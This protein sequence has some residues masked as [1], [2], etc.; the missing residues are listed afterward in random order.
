MYISSGEGLFSGA[1]SGY[2]TGR[3]FYYPSGA[4]YSSWIGSGTSYVIDTRYATA[5]AIL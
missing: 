4:D 1:S 5:N 3:Q 2:R